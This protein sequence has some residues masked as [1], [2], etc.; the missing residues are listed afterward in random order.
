M[1]GGG[2]DRPADPGQRSEENPP[3]GELREET[4]RE[5]DRQ[6]AAREVGVCCPGGQGR[7]C[8]RLE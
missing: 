6:T 3:Q 2:T 4:A 5:G 1:R 8:F 7:E